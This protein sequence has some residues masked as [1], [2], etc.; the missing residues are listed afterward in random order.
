MVPMPN[1]EGSLS[2]DEKMLLGFMDMYGY[3]VLGTHLVRYYVVLL[4]SEGPS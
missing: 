3:I 1:E 2:V 4:G